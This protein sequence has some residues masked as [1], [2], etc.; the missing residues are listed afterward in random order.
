[1]LDPQV[2]AAAICVCDEGVSMTTYSAK[3][4]NRD[5]LSS[6]EQHK[7]Q[8]SVQA[9]FDEAFNGTRDGVNVQ[10]GTGE[11]TDN[12][13]IHFVR[14]RDGAN[15]YLR[16]QFPRMREPP[17]YVGGHTHSHGALSGSELYRFALFRPV[18]QADGSYTGHVRRIPLSDYGALAFHEALHNLLPFW[19]NDTNADGTPNPGSLHNASGGGGFAAAHVGPNTRM[20][21]TNKIL[22]RRGFSVRNPQ[23]L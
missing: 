8:V 15:S 22:I 17:P 5:G 12:L 21:D 3:L 4:V 13:V 14:D 20:T 23:V 6:D 9:K 11:R 1:V 2:Q 7:I 16:S 10:W 18:R 19:P